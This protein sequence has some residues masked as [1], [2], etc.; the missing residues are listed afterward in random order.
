MHVWRERLRQMFNLNVLV[1]IRVNVI[2]TKKVGKALV[3]I[4]KLVSLIII[5]S[6]PIGF[7]FKVFEMSNATYVLLG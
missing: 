1:A 2:Y 4:S 6:I 7:V 3:E 5:I